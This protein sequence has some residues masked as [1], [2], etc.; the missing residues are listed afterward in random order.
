MFVCSRF[1]FVRCWK[2]SPVGTLAGGRFAM[3]EMQAKSYV[4]NVE[5]G[6]QRSQLDV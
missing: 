1:V 6:K 5:F 3:V 2:S 4:N